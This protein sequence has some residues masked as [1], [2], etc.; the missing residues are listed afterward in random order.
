MSSSPVKD[1]LRQ[2][3]SN[4]KPH[5]VIDAS[6]KAEA[7]AIKELLESESDRQPIIS[8]ATVQTGSCCGLSF[9]HASSSLQPCFETT[10]R[11]F[12]YA[13]CCKKH[14]VAFEKGQREGSIRT[15][16]D[17]VAV[18]NTIRPDLAKRF[19]IEFIPAFQYSVAK[20]VKIPLVV[21]V[22]EESFKAYAFTIN[23]VFK[24]SSDFKDEILPSLVKFKTYRYFSQATEDAQACMIFGTG[25]YSTEGVPIFLVSPASSSPNTPRSAQQSP[26]TASAPSTPPVATPSTPSVATPST[27][28]VATP[29][30]PSAEAPVLQGVYEAFMQILEDKEWLKSVK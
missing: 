5:N 12:G 19:Y 4:R 14:Q 18:V 3:L 24:S 30:A 22:S 8:R 29:V 1:R 10:K 27:P 25:D 23:D 28:S 17:V 21:Q 11:E 2:K 13:F 6:S 20:T 9:H 16:Y 15:F 7:E 26:R